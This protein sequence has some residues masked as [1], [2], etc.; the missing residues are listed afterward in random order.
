MAAVGRALRMAPLVGVTVGAVA[1]AVLALADGLGL[2]GLAA[3]LLAVAAGFWV[4]GGLHEDGL[5]DVADG[6]G[7]GGDAPRKL[8]I[9]RDS[10]VGTYGVAAIA[11]SVLLRAA[12]LAPLAAGAAGPLA[13]V[14]AHAL[15]RA[16]M[17]PVMRGLKPARADGLG[18]GAGRPDRGATATALILGALAALAALGPGPGGAAL[19]V[20]LAATGAVAWL[21]VRQIRGYTGDVLGAVEQTVETAVLLTA[22]AL[23]APA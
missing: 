13:L 10:R 17:V 5:A 14:A 15:G 22:A 7:G 11:L 21:A 23:L 16:A 20:A 8:A 1:G 3:A 6:F 19:L 9:M 2:P 4:T 18:H 12:A